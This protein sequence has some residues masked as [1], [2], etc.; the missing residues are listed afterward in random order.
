[1]VILDSAYRFASQ[2]S[3]WIL[4]GLRALLMVGMHGIVKCCVVNA[5]SS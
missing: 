1:M 2:V 4:I 5:N 3:K